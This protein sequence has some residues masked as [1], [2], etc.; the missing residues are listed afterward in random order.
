M[1]GKYLLFRFDS[2]ENFLF[3][4]LD[5]F[6]YQ[7]RRYNGNQGKEKTTDPI[8]KKNLLCFILIS[9]YRNFLNLMSFLFLFFFVCFPLLEAKIDSN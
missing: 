7:N 6:K 3:R 4:E 5:T 1:N 8:I 9:L 2:R